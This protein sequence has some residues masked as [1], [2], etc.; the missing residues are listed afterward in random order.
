MAALR[1]LLVVGATGKQGGAVID[2]LLARSAPFEILALTRNAS[3]AKAQS[4]AS[5]PNVKIVEGDENSAAAIFDAHKPIYGVFLV[6]MVAKGDAEEK[7]AKPFIDEAIKNGVEHFVFTSVER[8]GPIKSD[9]D[10]T[11]IPHFITKHNIEVYLKEQIA[12]KHSKMQWTFLRPVCFMDNLTPDFM[13]R[14]FASMWLGQGDKPLQMVSVHDI[15][16]YGA[17]AFMDLDAYKGRAISLAG[18]ELNLAQGKKVFKEIEGYAM[19]ET[20]SFVGSGIQWAMKEM[21]IM[22]N[23]FKTDGFG[24]D[25]ATL[26][27]EEPKLQDFATWLKESSKFERK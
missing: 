7:Q 17:R 23:W 16:V 27:K 22:F 24:A 13:G 18:D 3:S 6:T 20:Y 10:P 8:G 12:A 26:R 11:N 21:G 25:I 15:G 14:G 9:T 5:K 2:A 1:K 4:L 19:P